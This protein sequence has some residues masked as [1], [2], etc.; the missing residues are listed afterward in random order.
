M[1]E[2]ALHSLLSGILVRKYVCSRCFEKK[3]TTDS[4]KDFLDTHGSK[5]AKEDIGTVLYPSICDIC[6]SLTGPKTSVNLRCTVSR[7][8][9]VRV[10]QE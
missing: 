5:E 6:F 2:G 10:M 4:T 7:S 8:V 9:R 3:L 1:W